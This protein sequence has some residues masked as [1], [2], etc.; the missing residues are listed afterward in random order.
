MTGTEKPKTDSAESPWVRRWERTVDWAPYFTLGIGLAL[1]LTLSGQGGTDRLVT[2]GLSAVAAVWVLTMFTL[3]GERIA[4][5]GWVRAYFAGLIVTGA[6]LILHD[7]YFFVYVISGFFHAYLLRPTAL[8]FLGVFATS[9]VINGTVFLGAPEPQTL[10]ISL[11]VIAIQTAVIGL[12]IV[13]GEKLAELSEQ[14][15]RDVLELQ[16]TMAENESLHSQLLEQ[17]QD[18]A[19]SE[20]RERMAREIHDTIAQ[21]LI[22]IITQLE[23]GRVLDDPAEVGRRID[24]A[25]HLARESLEEARRSVNA[26]RPADLEERGLPTALGDTVVR[27][28]QLNHIPAEMSVTGE[29]QD[30]HPETEV[31]LLRVAQEALSN[32][33]KHADA[34]QV[35]V[36]LS[37]MEDM[38]NLDVKD[39]GRGFD[40]VSRN[41]GFGLTAMRQRVDGLGGSLSVESGDGSGTAMSV[42]LPIPSPGES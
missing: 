19:V 33:A 8:I 31:T 30:L 11:V 17:A 7:F 21:G 34:R 12:G 13:G 2:L 37:Y 42:A 22:G 24:N 35:R 3:A 18:R 14:R 5:Q 29:T 16:A 39:D 23:T 27:W 20:E 28:S 15:R 10:A 32:V 36:T 25:T 6:L 41:G 4:R 1:S 38:V 40:P 9:V 26:L